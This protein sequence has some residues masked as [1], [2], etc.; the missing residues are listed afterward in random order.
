MAV[1]LNAEQLD[2]VKSAEVTTSDG[3]QVGL[4]SSR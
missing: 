4:V 3:H 2:Q 1:T